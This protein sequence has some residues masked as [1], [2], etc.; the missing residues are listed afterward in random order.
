MLLQQFPRLLV[1]IGFCCVAL[2]ISSC[3]QRTP[4]SAAPS[5]APSSVQPSSMTPDQV[6]VAPWDKAWTNLLNDTRQTFTPS[7]PKLIAVEVQLV[8]GNPGPPKDTLTLT[9][10]DANERSVAV[11]SKTVP[12]SDCDRVHFVFPDDGVD[13]SPGQLYSL[14]LSGGPTFG[15][16]Y[17]V[18]GYE[19]G[20]ALFDGKPLLNDARSTFLFQTFGS[21]GHDNSSGRSQPL[22][23]ERTTAIQ[24]GVRAFMLTVSHDVTKEGP[25]AWSR[26]FADSPSFFMSVNGSVV[27]Q[28]SAAAKAAIPDIARSIKNIELKWGEDL[29]VDPLTPDLAVVTSSY[30][31]IRVDSSGQ[32]VDESGLFTATAEFRG[33]RWQFLNL[34]WSAHVPP[35]AVP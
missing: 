20:S 18:G 28:N 6:N 7:L 9:L 17:V 27:F 4:A 15:W 10:F 8:V 32:R 11:V 31:E 2:T 16:K 33:D 14:R 26:H 29:R 23:P 25:A 22:T 1:S 12:T 30:R 24:G 13:V 3:R 5:L 34:Q 19:N 35:P 21:S